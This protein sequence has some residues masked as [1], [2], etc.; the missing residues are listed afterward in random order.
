V[1]CAWSF[2]CDGGWREG[3]GPSRGLSV[4]QAMAPAMNAVW[5]LYSSESLLTVLSFGVV[6][7]V[8]GRQGCPGCLTGTVVQPGLE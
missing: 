4:G 8:C 5:I 3:L 1:Q 6:S 7:S 2:G